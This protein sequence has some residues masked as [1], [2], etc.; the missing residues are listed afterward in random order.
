M[1][2]LSKLH[3]PLLFY[4]FF[5]HTSEMKVLYTLLQSGLFR[6][7]VSH[8]EVVTVVT[9]GN[10]LLLVEG[11]NAWGGA[12]ESGQC[13]HAT[14]K[15]TYS[16]QGLMNKPHPPCHG[17]QVQFRILKVNPPIVTVPFVQR[18]QWYLQSLPSDYINSFSISL[19][20]KSGMFVTPS[21]RTCLNDLILKYIC[22]DK[23]DVHSSYQLCILYKY[24]HKSTIYF[25]Y[26]ILTVNVN[27]VCV[28]TYI[29][30]FLSSYLFG[31]P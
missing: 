3:V 10:V 14:F 16:L 19:L 9:G 29:S 27:V 20:G 8:P 11:G 31:Y 21:I 4:D 7:L 30:V 15:S 2:R 24:T 5:A 12:G 13:V 17:F 26:I 22:C 18:V 25:I 28:L 23:F 6:G 1:S